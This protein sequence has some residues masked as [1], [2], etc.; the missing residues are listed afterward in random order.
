MMNEIYRITKPHPTIP[1][2]DCTTI[3]A[4]TEGNSK[5]VLNPLDV[6]GKSGPPF[7]RRVSRIENVAKI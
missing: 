7:K 6:R 3:N 5:K 1:N 2:V 4:T